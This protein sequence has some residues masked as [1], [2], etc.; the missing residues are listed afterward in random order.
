MKHKEGGW[1]DNIDPT[2]PTE[3]AK[4]YKKMTRDPNLGY[5]QATKE[6]TLGA[7]KCILQNNEIDLF[8]EYFL[9]EEPEHLSESLTTKTLMI[10][11]DPN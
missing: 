7:T 9:G 10:F 8:E 6:M 11:K 2:E 1:P 3:R 5:A 4:Y